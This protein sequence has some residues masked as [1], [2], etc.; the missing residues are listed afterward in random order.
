M[1][2]WVSR[3]MDTV[4]GA[5]PSPTARTASG[6]LGVGTVAGFGLLAGLSSALAT[7]IHQARSATRSIEAAAVEAA[8]ADGTLVPPSVPGA[9][10]AQQRLA[11]YLVHVKLPQGDGV[12]AP[13]GRLVTVAAAGSERPLT[14]VMLGDSTSVGY[15]TKHAGELPGVILARGVAG[16]LDQPVRL[17]THGLTGAGSADLPRQLALGLADRPDAVVILI[18]G[19]DIRDMVP[20]GRSA[21]PLG[22]AVA[23]LTSH[24]VPVVVGTCP[25]FGVI[26]P[27]PQPLRLMLGGWSLRLAALQEREVRTAGGS[28]V[29]IAR[30]VSPQF[31]GRPDLFAPDRFHPSGPGYQRA[32]DVLLP[33]L[34]EQLGTGPA[35]QT[36]PIGPVIDESALPA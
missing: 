20:P 22:A 13:D 10:H 19:N 21:A 18:G 30:L 33:A 3:A 32:M 29:A 15:G 2:I 24:E 5:T 11:D 4:I 9:T 6:R 7:L 34:I 35:R 23:S 8:L 27:I 1:S 14:L 16:A 12:Y 17:C 26:S 36:Q 31:V 28:A 25:D